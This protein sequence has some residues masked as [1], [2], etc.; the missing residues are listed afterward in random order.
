MQVTRR[1]HLEK[2]GLRFES[3]EIK[4][5][6]K[7]SLPRQTGTFESPRE[8]GAIVGSLNLTLAGFLGPSLRAN[9]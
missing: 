9:D 8:A 3:T 2:R 6:R 7:P 1:L 5:D 4:N